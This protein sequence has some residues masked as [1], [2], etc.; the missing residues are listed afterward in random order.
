[1]YSRVGKK[2]VKELPTTIRHSACPDIAVIILFNAFPTIPVICSLRI[3]LNMRVTDMS[4]ATNLSLHIF[5]SVSTHNSK[6]CVSVF[7]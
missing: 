7:P 5:P 6:L 4:I 3:Q 1:M 2:S